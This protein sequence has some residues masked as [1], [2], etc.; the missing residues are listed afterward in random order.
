MNEKRSQRSIFFV[1]Y[2]EIVFHNMRRVS[3]GC[4]NGLGTDRFIFFMLRQ[5]ECNLHFL[6]YQGVFKFLF[7]VM[8]VQKMRSLVH[9]LGKQYGH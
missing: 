8:H 5:P 2:F 9:S 7:G 4:P 6:M 1:F 3:Y